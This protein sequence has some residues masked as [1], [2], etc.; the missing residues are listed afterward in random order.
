LQAFERFG[1]G[2]AA[3]RRAALG[4]SAADRAGVRLFAFVRM[5]FKKGRKAVFDATIKTVASR[6]YRCHPVEA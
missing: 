4:S 2:P 5:K 6:L 1:D 3:D